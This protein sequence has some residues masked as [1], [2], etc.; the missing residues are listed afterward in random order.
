[1]NKP[2]FSIII[3]VY[4]VEA[5]IRRCLESIFSQE[6]SSNL[7]EVIVVNDGT[8]DNSM[9]IIEEFKMH[10][11]NLIIY[12]QDNQGVSVAR[13][14]GIELSVGEYL[15]FV[16]PDDAIVQHSLVSLRDK[17]L[18]NMPELLIINSIKKKEFEDSW[19]VQYPFN[20]KL[21][22]GIFSGVDLFRFYTR[23]SVCGVCFN[24]RFIHEQKLVF[25]KEMKN[26]EDS[27]FFSLALA[28][29]KLIE[30]LK[31]NFYL[32]YEREGSAS[33]DWS[34]D[35]LLKSIEGIYQVEKELNNRV[36]A[37]PQK[38]I[39]YNQVFD[40]ISLT[41][42]NFFMKSQGKLD[43]Y[44]KLKRVIKSSDVYP[45]NLK[46]INTRILKIKLLNF[47]IDLFAIP[48]LVRALMLK[49]N[50]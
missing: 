23:G 3:P 16:D 35:R 26:S 42:Y 4:N 7:Y 34:Y 47:S 15:L 36:L 44:N 31:I 32:V 38:A 40:I 8:Q 9:A 21:C 41:F 22:N 20:D 25:N 12:S 27:L 46:G 2:F 5:Y 19:T 17:L 24:S 33:K 48:F 50:K 49:F 11:S 28:N 10:Y 14:K 18:K 29:A 37:P 30:L 1:M 43:N 13:N 39:L 45:I 6:L